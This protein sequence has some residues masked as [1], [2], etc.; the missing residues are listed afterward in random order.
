MVSILKL[1]HYGSK[2]A[3]CA[4]CTCTGGDAASSWKD[5]RKNA[6]WVNLFWKTGMASLAWPFTLKILCTHSWLLECVLRYQALG[7]W[8]HPIWFDPLHSVS[9]QQWYRKHKIESKYCS[10]R[11]TTVFYNQKKKI[12]PKFK[13]KAT[14]SSTAH[15]K[16]W[17]AVFPNCWCRAFQELCFWDGT[18]TQRGGCAFPRPCSLIVFRYS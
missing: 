15:W 13:G 9:M 12:A 16:H 7:H 17:R 8:C 14:P 11:K 4:I 10:F 5:C 3:P 1:P 2:K 6:A 18:V